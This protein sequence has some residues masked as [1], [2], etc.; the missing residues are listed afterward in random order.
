VYVIFFFENYTSLIHHTYIFFGA[1]TQQCLFL[2]Y[3]SSDEKDAE[4]Q[5][6]N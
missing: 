3:V 5:V 4:C 2:F 6:R 1:C